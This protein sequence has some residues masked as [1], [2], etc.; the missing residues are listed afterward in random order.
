MPEGNKIDAINKR[1]KKILKSVQGSGLS[2]PDE[3]KPNYGSIYLEDDDMKSFADCSLEDELTLTIK[4]KVTDLS[5]NEYDN[6][7]PTIR[8]SIIKIEKAEEE[9]D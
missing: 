8:M 6:D 5:I 4:V 9:D 1:T 3:K 2:M 7:K